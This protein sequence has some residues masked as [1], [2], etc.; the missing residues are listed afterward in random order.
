VVSVDLQRAVD[1]YMAGFDAK[2][3]AA[4]DAKTRLAQRMEADGFTLVTTGRKN[5]IPATMGR[6]GAGDEEEEGAD[7]GFGSSS[8]GAAGAAYES[9]NQKRK[10]ARG[11]LI[12]KDFY[13]FQQQDTKLTRLEE[14]RARF[15]EDKERIRKLKDTR[16]FRP[17]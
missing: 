8:A 3:A 4:H 7:D 5:A 17:Y 9:T 11:S 16:K 1:L 15:Q 6:A 2:E 12:M 10:K 14:L 13:A